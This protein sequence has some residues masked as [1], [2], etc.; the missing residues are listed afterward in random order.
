MNEQQRFF[1]TLFLC[2]SIYLGF[3]Y[4][5]PPP[6]PQ[7]ASEPVV[8]AVEPAA[9]SPSAAATPPATAIVPQAFAARTFETP[10]LKGTLRNGDGALAQ[11][12]LRA[13]N[14]RRSEATDSRPVSLLPAIE[15]GV[16]AQI[17]WQIDHP[18]PVVLDFA[19]N[20]NLHLTAKHPSGLVFDVDIAPRQDAYALD[21]SLRIR[22]DSDKAQRAGA[23]VLLELVSKSG[24]KSM[25]QSPGFFEKIFPS[26]HAD[27]DQSQGVVEEVTAICSMQGSLKRKTY[28]DVRKG[29]WNP[30]ESAD[31]IALDEQYFVVALMPKTPTPALCSVRTAGEELTNLLTFAPTVLASGQIWEQHFSLYTG[32]KRDDQLSQVAPV[33]QDVIDYTFLKIPLG[34]LARPMGWLLN[35]FYDLTLSWGVAIMLLTFAVKLVLFPVTYKSIVSMRRM[36]QLK[37]QLDAIKTRFAHDKE[38]QQM[39]QLKLFK[40][41]NVNPVGGCLPM[42]LQM[43][44]WL[45]LYRMLWSD[46]DLYQQPF[47][48]LTDLTAREPFPFLALTIGAITIVQQ[49]VTPMSGMD[50]QQAKVMMYVMPVMLTSF[51]VALPSGLVLYILVNSILTIVQQVAINRRT[52]TI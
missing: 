46:V 23:S 37:P 45:T 39:E 28:S 31:W 14:E 12:D 3:Q 4:M 44:V 21:Y 32:P 52:A 48:W 25:G 16:Q 50:N 7:T 18:E 35:V 29:F 47:L 43:P 33:L 24:L 8:A 51:M 42:L 2:M 22:N 40:E 30:K 6:P 34:F 26:T 5:F 38:R 10:L 36:Q 49:R 20:A 13:F 9:T 17:Q 15:K 11:L 27:A 19:N 1:L 41:A